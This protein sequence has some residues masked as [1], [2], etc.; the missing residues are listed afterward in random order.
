MQRA[1]G[2]HE[3][4]ALPGCAEAGN[5]LAKG[6]KLTDSLHDLALSIKQ[7]RGLLW[8]GGGAINKGSLLGDRGS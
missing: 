2:G 8:G 3:C 1:H 5:G 7:K 6:W 4:H